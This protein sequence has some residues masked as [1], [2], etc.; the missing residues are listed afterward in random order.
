[1][2]ANSTRGGWFIKNTSSGILYI[3]DIATATI[4]GASVD[5][6]P[7]QE[8][9]PSYV[10]TGALSII[11]ES[12]GQTFVAR[13]FNGLPNYQLTSNGGLVSSG[14]LTSAVSLSTVSASD[15]TEA[16]PKEYTAFV[17][18]TGYAIGDRLIQSIKNIGGVF[19]ESWLNLSQK[20][21]LTTN[22]TDAIV[23]SNLSS[24]SSVQFS[25]KRPVNKWLISGG[26]SIVQTSGNVLVVRN[27]NTF[28][29]R[30]SSLEM[31]LLIN[32]QQ[33]AL[34]VINQPVLA[35][36]GTG[37]TSVTPGNPLTCTKVTGN[38]T[39]VNDATITCAVGA[40]ATSA[41][42][43]FNVANWVQ[44]APSYSSSATAGFQ[45]TS[46]PHVSH[47]W[48]KGLIIPAGGILDLGSQ[49]FSSWVT[50]TYA[51]CAIVLTEL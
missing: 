8:Y 28:P 5:I 45:P 31:S 12:T 38:G 37:T 11:G 7:G 6:H 1:M 17:A 19:T 15:F 16:V 41:T 29:V 33:N 23:K 42:T 39:Y 30:V 9:E 4:S 50:S 10:S 36:V 24:F 26:H 32:I 40:T 2:A 27:T 47:D 18:G 49:G 20:T 44:Y 25:D 3:N 21:V 48:A 43:F 35:R 34:Q 14:P 13:E 22:P 51:V 46:H